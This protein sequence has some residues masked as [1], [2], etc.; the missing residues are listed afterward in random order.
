MLFGRKFYLKVSS[1]AWEFSD[2]VLM[3]DAKLASTML[4]C[5]ARSPCRKSS[6]GDCCDIAIKFSNVDDPSC[7]SEAKEFRDLA[8]NISDCLHGQ[9]EWSIFWWRGFTNEGRRVSAKYLLWFVRG[10]ASYGSLDIKRIDGSFEPI[11]KRYLIKSWKW[12]NNW[13]K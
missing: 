3:N 4:S 9:Q 11:V 10:S 1:T 6:K 7:G 8:R 2:L 5:I 12:R 13:F